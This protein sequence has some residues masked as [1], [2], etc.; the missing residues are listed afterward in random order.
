[1]PSRY[2]L[3]MPTDAQRIADIRRKI[4]RHNR[5]YY[6]E[7]KPEISDEEFDHLLADLEALER[8]HPDL[9]TADSPT[10]RVGGEPI[11]GF[12]TVPH[13]R[14]MFSID[15]TYR[16]EDLEAWHGRVLKGL[17]GGGGEEELFGGAIDY[18]LEPK[19][20]GVAV[21]LRYEQGHL[22]LALSRGDG[23]QG[24]DITHNVRTIRAVPLTLGKGQAAERHAGQNIPKKIPEVL[25]VRGEVYMPDAE[26]ERINRLRV[27]ADQE[28]FANPRNSTAGTLKQLDPRVVAQRRLM[29][30]AHG[31]GE[32]SPDPFES[33]SQFL[34][35]VRAW[36][37]PINPLMATCQR[38][39]EAWGFIEMFDSKRG[40]LGYGVDGVVVKVNGYAQQEQ[41][42]HTSKSPRWCIAYKYA[43]E[44]ATTVLTDITWQVGKGGTLTPVAELE[45]VF[46]AGTTVKRAGLHNIDEIQRKDVRVSDRVEIEKAGEIIPQVVGVYQEKRKSDN[47][48]TSQKRGPDS[49]PTQP[50]KRC[51]SCGEPVV[52]EEDEAAIR[53]V[54]PQCPAQLREKLIWFASRGQM[55]IEGLGDKAVNQLADAGLLG[56]IADIYGLKD[57]RD[58]LIGLER[59]GQKKVDN[60]VRG[61]EE[62]KGQGLARLLAGL[63]VRHVG[64]RAAQIL[65]GH[66]GSIQKLGEAT[67]DELATVPEIGPITAASV[68]HF[69]HSRAGEQIIEGLQSCGVD[70]TFPL[71][72]SVPAQSP[73]AGKTV[74]LTGILEHYSREALAEKL[75]S[76][77]AKVTGSVSKKTDLLIAGDS[78]GSKLDKAS[79]LGVEVWN[80]AH[81]L[82]ILSDTHRQK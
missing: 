57:H 52:R 6:V 54:N 10:Q 33:H 30:K 31:R 67:A 77:G 35:A 76:L 37:L 81:L 66:Y 19:I 42:G 9:V 46:L 44:R 2:N 14:R 55:D 78:P 47:K 11:S 74:V 45:P 43:A 64:T 61:I 80:E 15:N 73:F 32:V 27:E 12:S 71:K 7:A 70:M 56:S 53:C 16:R 38:V 49:K 23:Q 58:E 62:S 79:R 26:F 69:I 34:A 25:E 82:E 65:A 29:F 60:L 51:P 40:S 41:L 3:A 75:Q 72:P 17:G 5:L 50:P 22:V 24:D 8:A 13:A 20:D 18:V 59:M 21:S 39:N 36:G 48:P 63:G 28:P 4:E 1:M 68:H